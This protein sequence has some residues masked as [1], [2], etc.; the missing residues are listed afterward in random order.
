M[1]I[2]HLIET[3]ALWIA[4]FAAAIAALLL[5]YRY[6]DAISLRLLRRKTAAPLKPEVKVKAK[7]PSKGR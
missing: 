3:Y 2:F 7:Q 6:R 4:L 5:T 1:G